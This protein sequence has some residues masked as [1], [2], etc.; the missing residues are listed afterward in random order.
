MPA[1]LVS[2]TLTSAALLGFG[3]LKARATGLPTLR[4]ALQTFGIGGAAAVVAYLVA[5]LFG[6]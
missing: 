2:C 5:S 4:G 3:W 6:H 1:L